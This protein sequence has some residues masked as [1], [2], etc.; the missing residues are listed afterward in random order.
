M[1]YPLVFALGALIGWRRAARRG[2]DRLDKIHYAAIHGIALTLAAVLV[3]IV[4][5]ALGLV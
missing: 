5:G 1:I 3:F 2:G 4:A